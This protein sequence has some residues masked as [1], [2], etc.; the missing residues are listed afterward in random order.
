MTDT[1][2]NLIKSANSLKNS[3]DQQNDTIRRNLTMLAEVQLSTRELLAE[4][5]T[6]I[7]ANIAATASDGG[8][9]KL[10]H[11]N[12]I[13]AFMAGVEAIANAMPNS[14]DKSKVQNT[15]RYLQ[16]A[17][18]GVDGLVT[19]AVGPIAELGAQK[20]DLMAKYSQIIKAYVLS[21]SRGKPTGDILAQSARALQ[22]SIDQAMRVA[23]STT[24]PQASSAPAGPSTPG[25]GPSTL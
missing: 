14:Q 2:L 11:L 12:S 17:K 24:A 25:V 16:S 8:E 21:V 13:A 23:T 5:V 10:M 1:R 19:G 4:N 22:S 7:L 6:H 3:T 9:L 18:V 20:P 15:L